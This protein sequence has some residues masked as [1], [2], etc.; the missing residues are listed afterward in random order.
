MK[1]HFYKSLC[2]LI[3]MFRYM[4][5]TYYLVVPVLPAMNVHGIQQI[6]IFWH[7]Y[8]TYIL[9]QLQ[10]SNFY[11]CYIFQINQVNC[12]E[13]N[14]LMD[15]LM[16]FLPILIIKEMCKANTR[17]GLNQENV[18]SCSPLVFISMG[19]RMTGRQLLMSRNL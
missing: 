9:R 16:S 4:F 11:Y 14:H 1:L 12:I 2:S 15:S 10:S 8:A 3:S 7:Q 17:K 13:E 19:M 6:Q 18:L 5:R